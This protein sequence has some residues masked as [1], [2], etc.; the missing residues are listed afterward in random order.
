MPQPQADQQSARNAAIVGLAA[1]QLSGLWPRVDWESPDA[2]KAVSTVYGGI[3]AR[4]GQA[5]AAVAAMQYDEL[6]DA[7]GVKSNYV[8][9]PADPIGQDVIEKVVRSA[10]LGNDGALGRADTPQPG[11]PASPAHVVGMATTTARRPGTRQATAPTSSADTTSDLPV[12]ER[13]P[14]RL[15]T[16]LQRRVMQP[17]RDTVALNVVKDPEQPRYVRVPRGDSACAFCVMLASRDI[18]D[19][20]GK[21]IDMKYLAGNVKHDPETD[22]LHVFAENGSKFHN[23]CQCEAVPIFGGQHIE[24]VSPNFADYVDMYYKAAADAGT[25][26]DTKKIL[27]SMRQLHGLS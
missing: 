2:V 25:H 21:A 23:H 4:F 12:E 22:R 8:A 5:T 17:A 27:A 11:T 3:V 26:R 24:D 1:Q 7:Q 10:F 20:H 13:V 16:S 18:A 14:A 19:V 6:R 9:D 15:T